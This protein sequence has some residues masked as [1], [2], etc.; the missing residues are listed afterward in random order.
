MRE[1]RRFGEIVNNQIRFWNAF[2]T[3]LMG[4]YGEGEMAALTMDLET[5]QPFSDRHFCAIAG[6]NLP[7]QTVVGGSPACDDQQKQPDRDRVRPHAHPTQGA[8]RLRSESSRLTS[9][10][11]A[12]TR[13]SWA[14]TPWTAA[15]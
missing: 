11:M 4:T 14:T 15:R 1:I 10:A 7:D 13:K 3:I 12:V 2:W 6:L 5:A 9:R 8:F